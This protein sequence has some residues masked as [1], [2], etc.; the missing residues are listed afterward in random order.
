MIG[1]DN[2][3]VEMTTCATL[4]GNEYGWRIE[5]F[6]NALAKAEA[7]GYACL[8]GQFQFRLNT[9]ICEIYWLSADSRERE[10]NEIWLD[11]CHRSSTEVLNNFNKVVSETD[12]EEIAGDWP[13]VQQAM[14]QGV[15]PHQVLVFVAYFV[16][17]DE[18]TNLRKLS[19]NITCNPAIK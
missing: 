11:Y 9:G 16:T 2:L 5:S 4:D 1:T 18:Y 17:E 8:G 19:E 7:F 3:P 14:E 15:D 12:F 6:P 10:L 13:I